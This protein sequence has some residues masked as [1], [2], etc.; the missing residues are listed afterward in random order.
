MKKVTRYNLFFLIPLVLVVIS[1]K[2]TSVNAQPNETRQAELPAPPAYTCQKAPH[3]IQITGKMD[4]PAWQTAKPLRL[5]DAVTGETGR[6]RTEVRVLYDDKFLYV[7][8]SCEDDYVWGTVTERNGPIWDEECV[9]VFINPTGARHQY[10]EI[11]LSPKNVIFDACVLNNR[12][13]Q[14]DTALFTPLTD[15]N[16]KEM[17]T[18]AHVDGQLDQPGGA[19]GWTAEYAIPFTE[20]Y[21]A[22]NQ[23][24]KP[25]DEWRINFYRIDSPEKGQ[26]DHYA[27]SPTGR[28]A[29]HLPWR[30]G[31][32]R[33]E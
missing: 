7:G 9:E 30:F 32:L 20:L 24:P 19:K 26:R 15:F 22:P 8:F 21:G 17:K 12:T 27:W 16:L 10:Y 1:K 29:F 25:G 5:T 28:V 4:D 18:A 23:P 6:F 13:A 31:V 14:R 11:N 3:P 33:F 2:E